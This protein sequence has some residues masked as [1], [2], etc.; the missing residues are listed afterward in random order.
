[1]RVP[2]VESTNYQR[3]KVTKPLMD[4]FSYEYAKIDDRRLSG[5]EADIGLHFKNVDFEKLLIHI[6]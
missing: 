3:I 1:M 2:L 4:G 6:I 5:Q